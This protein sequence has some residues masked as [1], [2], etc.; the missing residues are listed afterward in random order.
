M[1]AA[2]GLAADE[3]KD[4]IME[5]TPAID[6]RHLLDRAVDEEFMKLRTDRVSKLY[7]PL[8]D[9]MVMAT[10]PYTDGESDALL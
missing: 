3:R 8:F 10:R 7:H 4:S 9:E 1:T 6:N 5:T 2:E